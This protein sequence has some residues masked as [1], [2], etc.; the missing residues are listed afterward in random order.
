M[1]DQHL[2]AKCKKRGK[3]IGWHSSCR[4]ME[5]R[6]DIVTTNM[7]ITACCVHGSCLLNEEFFFKSHIFCPHVYWDEFSCCSCCCCFLCVFVDPYMS[8]IW[9][10]VISCVCLEGWL[11]VRLCIAKTFSTEHYTEIEF[12]DQTFHLTLSQYTDTGPT[13]PSADPKTPGVW[14]GSHWSANFWVTGMT[15]SCCCCPAIISQNSN[16]QGI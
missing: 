2:Q 12:A 7:R 11:A 15:R 16:V 14:Q 9:I 3:V 8:N 5:V 4:N 1:N 6:S 13:S 10:Y